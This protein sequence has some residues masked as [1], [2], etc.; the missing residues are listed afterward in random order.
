MSSEAKDGQTMPQLGRD[1]QIPN[2]VHKLAD[3]AGLFGCDSGPLNDIQFHQMTE[4]P[5]MLDLAQDDEN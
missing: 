4:S 3:V 1:G 2:I 5:R